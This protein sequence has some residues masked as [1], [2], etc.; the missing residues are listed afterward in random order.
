[1]NKSLIIFGIVNITSD[2]F[3]DGGRY[4]AP[5][6]AIA[7]A[8][9]LMAEGAD[10]IDLG[11]A[12]SNPDAAPVSS[13]TEI[14]RIAPVLDALKADGIP[15]S[16]DSYQP[17]TQAYALSR[18]VAYLN[19]IR[20]FPDA[21]FYPQL[22]KSSAKLVVMHSVQDGQADRREAPAGDIMDHIAAFFD[23][24][25]AALTGAGIKRNRL[26]LDPGMGFFLG[27]AP[28]TSLSVLAR[29]D[30]LRLRFD[31]PVLLS[32]SRKS[33]LRA[34]TGR[35]PGD[36]GAAT[37]AAELAAA[38][39]GADFIRTHE[40]RPLRDGLAVLAALNET[41]RIR[42]LHIRDIS[43]YS[44]FIRKLKEP[45]LTRTNIFLV[46][47][48][49]TGCLSEAEN[50]VILFFDVVTGMPSRKS[51][52]LPAAVSS[53]ESVTASFG[54]KVEVWL[55]PRSSTGRRNRRVHAW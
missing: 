47:R 32:V 16:L 15:V 33:F 28:E 20:G 39:G 41:A 53:L 30:E 24:R 14:E 50:L 12:S 36:V 26:V 48:I 54:S 27:A 51:H 5:D 29:F 55:A 43:L 6:A 4:L 44:R 21:A 37:L 17:A 3:S 19:D 52:L 10:V 35:G 18:G 1:M 38:A 25:I 40:P 31:L 34:L 49:L 22:A 46:N 23:A 7:Q 45:P 13:D 8:R 2:S 11:P 42:S 9:K